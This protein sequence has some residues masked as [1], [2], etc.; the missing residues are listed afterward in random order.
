MMAM[1][2][3]LVVV[4]HPDDEVLGCGG[5]IRRLLR[6]KAQ[7]RIVILGEGS[8]CRFPGDRLGTGEVLQAI[9]QR[10]AFG[11]AAFRVLGADNYVFGDL[12]CGRFDTYPVIDIGKQ[13]EAEIAMFSP[14]TVITHWGGDTNSDHRI[15]FNAVATATRPVPGSPVRTVLSCEIPSS[16]EWRFVDSFAPNLFIDIADDLDAKIAAFDCYAATE[17]RPFPFP[18]STEGLRTLA[19]Y[20]G[21]Q[22]SLEAAEAFQVVRSVYA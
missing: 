10:R 19:R 13:V 22:T 16:T 8:S 4:A 15:T 21:M 3:I 9:A 14:D 12:R 7:V 20:R 1:E 2:R 6:R 11:E 18:R 5:T 17:G